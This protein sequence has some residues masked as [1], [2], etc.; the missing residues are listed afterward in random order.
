MS[1]VEEI[2]AALK[3]LSPEQQ[4]D[5]QGFLADLTDAVWTRKME[6]DASAGKLDFLFEEGAA[7]YHSG[8]LREWPNNPQP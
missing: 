4:L 8:K 2:K 7:E 3:Q 1:T 6:A 5:V